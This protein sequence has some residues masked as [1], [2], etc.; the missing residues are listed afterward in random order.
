M[1]KKQSNYSDN[2]IKSRR[3]KYLDCEIEFYIYVMLDKNKNVVYVGKTEDINKRISSHKVLL[4]EY[5]YN[6]NMGYFN[7]NTTIPAEKLHSIKNVLF[8]KLDNGYYASIY[9]AH[10]IA[11]YLPVY[12]NDLKYYSKSFIQLPSLQWHVYI[13]DYEKIVWRYC[14]NGYIDE[15][16]CL[17]IAKEKDPIK[18]S[19]NILHLDS[20]VPNDD[21]KFF[22]TNEVCWNLMD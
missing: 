14:L 2:K 4:Q 21:D 17:K 1:K 10:L 22:N 13:K 12:N 7:Y 19:S 8:S 18:R 20:L 15:V 16:E 9:E 11:K 3:N 5:E 6:F